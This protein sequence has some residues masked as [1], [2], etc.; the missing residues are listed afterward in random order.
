MYCAVVREERATVTCNMYR[1]FVKFG[2]V[3]F[4]MHTSGRQGRQWET[5]LANT[6]D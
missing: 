5:T 6:R 4:E 3:I 2:H 1:K